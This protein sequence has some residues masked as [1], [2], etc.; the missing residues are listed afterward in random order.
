MPPSIHNLQSESVD[1]VGYVENLES[2]LLKTRVSIA[3]LRYG[4][5]V[6]G[7][8]GE[9]LSYGIPTVT[10]SI[11]AEG[12]GF[13]G[14]EI[15][16]AN[17]ADDF[18]QKCI[19]LFESETLWNFMS[20]KGRSFIDARYSVKAAEKQIFR[21]LSLK[22]DTS[23]K[24]KKISPNQLP[25]FHKKSRLGLH[26]GTLLSDIQ[27]GLALLKR[28]GILEFIRRLYWYARGKKLP[29]ELP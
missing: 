11:G 20:L 1:V 29:D 15:M 26:L 24:N 7:K 22:T 2:A 18:A 3:P 17:K 14:N 27:L 12:F 21:L 28:E 8:I 6:K 10:T 23:E 25:T 9:A 5:G 4:A 16:V 13:T 19:T